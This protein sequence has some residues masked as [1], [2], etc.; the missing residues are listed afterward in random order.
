MKSILFAALFTI[1][2]I[3]NSMA[4]DIT[5]QG[6][7]LHYVNQFDL[8]TTVDFD[9]EDESLFSEEGLKLEGQ[10][11]T[12]YVTNAGFEQTEGELELKDLDLTVKFVDRP[13]VF[14]KPFYHLT[15]L[16]KKD[17]EQKVHVNMTVGY[18]GI[19]TSYI[20]LDNLRMYKSTCK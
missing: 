19:M 11:L 6:P 13:D 15:F 4:L 17:A 9:R 10:N 12:A 1:A 7:N 16:S 18:P 14:G 5:C 3:T 20:R 2:L 8:Q